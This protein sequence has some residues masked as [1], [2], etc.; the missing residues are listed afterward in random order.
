MP[1]TKKAYEDPELSKI[2]DRTVANKASRFPLEF[3]Q[4]RGEE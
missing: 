1:E 2:P 4:V 3:I